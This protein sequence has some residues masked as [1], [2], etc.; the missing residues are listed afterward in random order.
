M[1]TLLAPKY[2][3]LAYALALVAVAAIAMTV[4]MVMPRWLPAPLPAR[5]PAAG[6]QDAETTR[7]EQA[8]NSLQQAALIER[9]QRTAREEGSEAV[10]PLHSPSAA[11]AAAIESRAIDPSTLNLVILE[12]GHERTATI[13]GVRVRVGERTAGGFVV[14]AIEKT[15]IVIEDAAGVRRSVDL[16][17]R[18]VRQD[19]ASGS[20]PSTTT[21][22]GTGK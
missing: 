21:P 13:D 11:A 2:D 5:E 19:A 22:Q 7:I 3:A 10:I 18:F 1:K 15:G 20:A 16:R 9:T 6:P 4:T 14:R 17:D 8:T 12:S